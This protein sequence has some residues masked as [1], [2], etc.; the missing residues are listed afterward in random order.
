MK[1]KERSPF[2]RPRERAILQG[3]RSLSS[4][5]LLCLLIGS[6]TREQSVEQV[7]AQIL[8]KT[9]GLQQLFTI[10]P[11]ELMEIEGIGKARALQI[12]A[13][14]ELASRALEAR[15]ISSP[16]TCV[17]DVRGWFQAVYGSQNQ[18]H[19]AVLYLDRK[20]RILRYRDLFVGTLDQSLVHPREIFKEACLV[21]ACGI[22]LVH[23]HPSDDPMPSVADLQSTRQLA[24]AAR[25]HRIDLIDH[26]IV[27]RTSCFSFREHDL[28]EGY[29]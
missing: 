25:I 6:G 10:Q 16:V 29:D 4:T 22:L 20:N 3:V 15:A 12:C 11:E 23:N 24:E 27:G 2:E 18:E 5:E 7:A 14:V 1:I 8:E 26:I 9:R 21:S 19:F 13:A 17:D 28:L